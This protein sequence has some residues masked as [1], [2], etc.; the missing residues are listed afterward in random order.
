MLRRQYIISRVRL[1]GRAPLNLIR[2]RNELEVLRQNPNLTRVNAELR[3]GTEPGEAYLDVQLAESNPFQL[4]LQISNRRSPSV[5]AEQ[6]EIL[7]SDR[8]LTGN[9]DVLAVR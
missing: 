7:A 4:G 2:L 3:P 1:G 8:N 6:V 5:G 9:G